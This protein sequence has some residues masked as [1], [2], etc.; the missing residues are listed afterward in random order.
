M[1]NLNSQFDNH[2]IRNPFSLMT[3]N[4]LINFVTKNKVLQFVLHES[5]YYGMKIS[6]FFT[7][8]YIEVE[9][10]LNMLLFLLTNVMPLLTR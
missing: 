3:L 7:N 8:V 2:P 9:A 6:I 5:N 10:I 4:V 1:L